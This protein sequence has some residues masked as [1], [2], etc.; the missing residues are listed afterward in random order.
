MTREKLSVV[1]VPALAIIAA[2]LVLAVNAVAAGDSQPQTLT[3]GHYDAPSCVPAP[4]GLVSWW[5]GDGNANDIAGTNNG[6]LQDGATFA[7]GEVGQAFSLSGGSYVD[8]PN[9][10]SLNLTQA[11]SVQAWILGNSFDKLSA[12]VKKID[13]SQENGYAMEMRLGGIAFWVYLE[14]GGWVYAMSTTQLVPNTWYH[15]VGTYDGTEIKL[16]LNGAPQGTSNVTGKIIAS[17]N[18]LNIGR[19]PGNP[20][21][22]YRF[23]NGLIDEVQIY[24]RALTAAEVAAIYDAGSAGVCKTPAAFGMD[25]SLKAGDVPDAVWQ[26]AITNGIQAVVVNAWTGGSQG[27]C[28]KDQLV[29][30]GKVPDKCTRKPVGTKGAQGNELATGA[31]AVLN[32][33]DGNGEDNSGTH[34]INQALQ[35]VGAGLGS[36]KFM[37]VDVE[38]CC[39]EFVNWQ[40]NHKY[41]KGAKSNP[42]LIM[43]PSYHIQKV[44]TAGTSGSAKP[45][46]NDS[47]GTT[48]DPPD[49]S[50]VVWQ[51]TG[52][53][54]IDQSQR[55]SRICEAIAT[56]PANLKAVIYTYKDIWDL[57]AGSSPCPDPYSSVDL[58]KVFLWDVEHDG[59]VFKDQ[60]GKEYCGDGPV[61]LDAFTPYG[62]WTFRSG[63]QYI[64]SN[65]AGKP[66]HWRCPGTQ[67]FFGV[68]ADLDLFSTDLLQ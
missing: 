35:A 21:V 15:V 60:D 61:G 10:A 14:Q 37:A 3:G 46:W 59:E 33:L 1:V 38:Q 39:G 4:A 24:N 9:A 40:S 26:T 41:T 27:K 34:Q 5:P 43:D 16:Y 68:S 63:D 29:G 36:L 23:W 20:G 7:A 50:G 52:Y 47:G 56:V 54:V 45:T 17:S 64:W 58:S 32:Y 65:A 18:D 22:D 62:P 30:D 67:S 2:T 8:V 42:T 66:K 12:V 55:L 51:D 11:I 28:A 44:I 13:A 31:Y 25:V 48:K 19:D 49:G 57:I 53:I 6:T